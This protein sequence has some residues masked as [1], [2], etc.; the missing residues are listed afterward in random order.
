MW[1]SSPRSTSRMPRP[2]M[3]R[4]RVADLLLVA[5]QETLAIADGLVLAR[6]PAIDDVLHEASA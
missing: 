4:D 5:A 6:Q 1:M 2:S 3:A